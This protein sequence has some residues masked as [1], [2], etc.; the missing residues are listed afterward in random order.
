MGRRE[1]RKKIEE[2]T[3]AKANQTNTWG[4]GGSKATPEP[5]TPKA[6][7]RWGAAAA[8]KE[9]A[10]PAPAATPKWGVPAAKPPPADEAVPKKKPWEK[11]SAA[12]KSTLPS[13]GEVGPKKTT[14][15][16]TANSN[17]RASSYSNLAEAEEDSSSY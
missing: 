10:A 3:K 8:K 17:L 15:S 11:P 16:S 13:L 9:E 6:K 14:A 4:R 2:E 1:E 5:E 7:P 12:A